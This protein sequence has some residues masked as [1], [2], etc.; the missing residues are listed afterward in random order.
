[1]IKDLQLYEIPIVNG[2]PDFLHLNLH[3]Y[4][5]ASAMPQLGSLVVSARRAFLPPEG[6]SYAEKC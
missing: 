6:N 4:S 1:M 2:V 5:F 3:K